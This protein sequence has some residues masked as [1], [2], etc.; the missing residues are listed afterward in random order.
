MSNRKMDIG[1][2]LSAEDLV[3]VLGAR[4]STGAAIAQQKQMDEA[5]SEGARPGAGSPSVAGMGRPV[6]PQVLMGNVAGNV[7][8]RA[9]AVQVRGAPAQPQPQTRP[10]PEVRRSGSLSIEE[11]ERLARLKERGV[12]TD[13]EFALMKKKLLGG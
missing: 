2:S 9:K 10:G 4:S 5:V 11:L 8:E 6:R 3:A 1:N 12:I 7:A 13:V